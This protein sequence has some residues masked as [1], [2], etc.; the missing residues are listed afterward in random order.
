MVLIYLVFSLNLSLNQIVFIPCV[1][2]THTLTLLVAFT[3]SHSVFV[4]SKYLVFLYLDYAFLVY[5]REFIILLF[6]I[7][8]QRL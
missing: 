2:H 7:P 6:L 4:L 3:L 5:V 8:V 1:L